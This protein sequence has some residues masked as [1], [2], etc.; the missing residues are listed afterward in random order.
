M[1]GDGPVNDAGDGPRATEPR[2]DLFRDGRGGA[3]PR[4]V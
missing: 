4:G 2:Y 3:T 1:G